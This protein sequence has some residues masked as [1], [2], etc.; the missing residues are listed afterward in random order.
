MEPP[1][2][3]KEAREQEA[4]VRK[5]ELENIRF[6]GAQSQGNMPAWKGSR[7]SGRKLAQGAVRLRAVHSGTILGSGCSGSRQGFPAWPFLLA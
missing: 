6:R 7:D 5:A 1:V 2:G 4:F 3:L